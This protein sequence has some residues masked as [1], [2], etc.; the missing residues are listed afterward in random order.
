[1]SVPLIDLQLF[2]SSPGEVAQQM[3]NACRD[4]GF[5]YIKSPLLKAS[6][7]DDA[8][9]A[10]HALFDMPLECKEDVAA[11]KSP[12][13]RGYQGTSSDSHSCTPPEAGNPTVAATRDLKES[14]AI[15]ALGNDSHMHGENQWP[16]TKHYPLEMRKKLE[17]YWKIMLEISKQVSTCLALSLGLNSSF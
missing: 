5:F 17:E 7:I 9:E 1:M 8:F 4:V 14:Y 16:E 3:H 12:L 11:H 6:H 13:F 10:V 15:G 2:E